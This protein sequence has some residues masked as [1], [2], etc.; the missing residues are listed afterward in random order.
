MCPTQKLSLGRGWTR[1]PPPLFFVSVASKGLGSLVKFF[2]INTYEGRVASV[3]SKEVSLHKN[4]A[5]LEDCQ[6][7]FGANMSAGELAPRRGELVP[8]KEKREQAPALQT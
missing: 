5:T 3:D 8:E 4:G 1:G 2:R 7:S 6:H